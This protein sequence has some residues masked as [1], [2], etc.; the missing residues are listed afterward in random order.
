MS[1]VSI[2]SP[3]SSA[4]GHR[5]GHQRRRKAK[6]FGLQMTSLMDVLII[7]VI[8]L[9][10]SYGLSQ[11]QVPQTDKM[12]LPV[13]KAVETFGEG[14]VLVIAKDQVTVDSEK[15]L[16]FE[17]DYK[18]NKFKVPEAALDNGSSNRGILPIYDVLKKK[19]EDFDTLASRSPQP[20]ESA[21]KWTGELLVQAD[22]EAPYSLIR[23]VMF[24]AG[25]AGYKT[26][27]LTV[28]KRPE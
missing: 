12:E 22:K 23:Q 28:E 25:M 5:R 8:F 17:G 20:V 10:K 14:I 6:A 13:S 11:M 16:D 4:S 7:I 24:T 2:P 21:K 9:L 18:E 3:G 19:K 26:F 15:V 1:G 27:R